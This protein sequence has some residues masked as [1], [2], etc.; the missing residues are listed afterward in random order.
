VA[1][2]LPRAH[3]AFALPQR[4]IYKKIKHDPGRY[5]YRDAAL[6][7]VADDKIE[8][9][10]LFQ[11]AVAQTYVDRVRRLEEIQRGHAV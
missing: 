11:S 7:P 6:E 9:G 10:E 4:L 8:T 5:Q 3:Q 2:L 1:T